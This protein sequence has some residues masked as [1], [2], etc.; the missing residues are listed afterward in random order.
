MT[1][2]LDNKLKKVFMNEVVNKRLSRCQQL[3]RL[4]KFISEYAVKELIGENEDSGATTTLTNFIRQYYPEPKDKDRV[5]YEI[6]TKN[7][8]TLFDEFK[9]RVDPKEGITKVEIPSLG[10][11]DA[12]IMPNILMANKDLLETGMWGTAKLTYQKNVLDDESLQTPI[13]ITEFNPLQY[14]EINI[15]DYK[16][17]REEFTLEEWIDVLM[18]TLGMNPDAYTER[19]KILYISR[20]IPLV[21]NN[22]NMIEFGPRATGKS[23][24]FK[25]VSWYVRLYSGGQVSPAVLFY[26]GT[27]KTLGDLG[28]RDLVVFDEV[29]RID[30]KNPDEIMGK[31]KDYMESG[32]F[33]RGQ[34]KRSRSNCSL[35]FQGNIEV[36][37][38]LPAEDFSTVMPDC[39]NDSAF[40]DRIHG[41]IPGWEMPKVKQSDVH[42]CNGY[43]LITDY[44]CEVMHELRKEHFGYHLSKRIVLSAEDGEVTIRD[45][46]A[47]QRVC[48]GLLKLLSPH[49]SNNSE[50]L[51][52]AA[53][54]A[55][56]YRQRVHDWLCALSPGEF[57]NKIIRYKIES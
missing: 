28:V 48:G 13:L 27:F 10:V 20:L 57:H 30:F 22:V 44:F 38:S 49:D 5:L 36:E 7:E 41:I 15:K 16:K 55:V 56:E 4:P 34:L 14:G 42:L 35:M 33:E 53:K 19:T 43:G 23:F 25:N 50:A 12:M 6:T 37:K 40:I 52:I 46:K 8:Y 17:R 9:V 2:Q 54:I 18:Q 21:E 26:H 29:S 24:L 47:I 1:E 39:M 45:Q 3:D 31:F 32:E 11:R 51:E